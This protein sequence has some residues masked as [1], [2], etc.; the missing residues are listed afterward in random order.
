MSNG[1]NEKLAEFSIV[2]KFY[3]IFNYGYYFVLKMSNLLNKL[4][5]V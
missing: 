3:D 2:G 4:I 1:Y 5:Y